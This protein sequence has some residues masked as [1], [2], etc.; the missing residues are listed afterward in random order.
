[1]AQLLFNRGDDALLLAAI[2]GNG[3]VAV[4]D[5]VPT[6]AIRSDAHW[7]RFNCD[8][9]RARVLLT[10]GEHDQTPD[11]LVVTVCPDFRRFWNLARIASDLRL[12][13][14]IVSRLR[15]AGGQSLDDPTVV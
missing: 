15:A 11:R 8:Q 6:T 10:I 2:F 12:S 13:S 1:M 3:D 4:S 7:T 14:M 5:Y 9:S